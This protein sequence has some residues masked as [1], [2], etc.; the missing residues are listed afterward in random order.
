MMDHCLTIALAVLLTASSAQSTC[1]ISVKVTR[2][3][4]SPVNYYNEI[5]VH[6]QAGDSVSIGCTGG[7]KQHLF[8]D[9]EET[10]LPL[11]F[12]VNG[13]SLA[14]KNTTYRCDCSTPDDTAE[15][16][17]QTVTIPSESYSNSSYSSRVI[18]CICLL[19]AA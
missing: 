11:D 2:S 15:T 14:V 10:D 16:V 1:Q 19:C 18:Q 6:V 3:N 7:I 13:E 17:I 8:Q 4:S 9:G 5:S 12:N